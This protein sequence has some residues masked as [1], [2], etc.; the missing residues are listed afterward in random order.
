MSNYRKALL[1]LFL[2]SSK[3]VGFSQQK[4]PGGITGTRAWLKTTYND[5]KKEY[6]WKNFS[7]DTIEVNNQINGNA[8]FDHEVININFNPSLQVSNK[9]PADIVLNTTNLSQATVMGVFGKRRDFDKEEFIYNI[10]GRETTDFVVTTDGIF[11][12][13]EGTQETLD[14]GSEIGKDLWYEEGEP[15]EKDLKTFKETTHRILTYQYHEQPNFSIWGEPTNAKIKLGDVLDQYPHAVNNQGSYEWNIPEFFIYDREL[16]PEER[17]KAETYLAL[18]YG[19]TLD[20]N[21]IDSKDQVLWDVEASE[22]YNNR[23]TGIVNDT[24][25]GLY[26]P[27]SHTSNEESFEGNYFSYENDSYFTAFRNFKDF[28]DPNLVNVLRPTGNRLLTIGVDNTSTLLEEDGTYAL[29][30]DDDGLLK[31]KSRKDIGGAR[32]LERTWKIN[33]NIDGSTSGQQTIGN[34]TLWKLN[35]LEFDTDDGVSDLR[36]VDPDIFPKT[37]ITTTPLLGY[38]G[39]VSVRIPLTHQRLAL[40]FGNSPNVEIANNNYYGVEIRYNSVFILKKDGNPQGTWF[41]NVSGDNDEIELIK[42]KDEILLVVRRFD[43]DTLKTYSIPIAEEDKELPFYTSLISEPAHPSQRFYTDLQTLR[44]FSGR[45]F[46]EQEGVFAEL[47]IKNGKANEFIP[48]RLAELD[49]ESYLIIDKTGQGDFSSPSNLAFIERSRQSPERGNII[50]EDFLFDEDGSGSDAFTFGYKKKGGFVAYLT[51]TKPTCNTSDVSMNDGA[52]AVNV[53]FGTP[54]FRYRLTNEDPTV[55][56]SQE[57]ISNSRTFNIENISSGDY[58]LEIIDNNDATVA[59]KVLLRAECEEEAEFPDDAPIFNFDTNPANNFEPLPETDNTISDDSN[60]AGQR[61]HIAAYPVPVRNGDPIRVQV[62]IKEQVTIQ[63]IAPS[64][65]VV[66]HQQIS[67]S[68]KSTSQVL[69]FDIYT[70]PGIYFLEAIKANGDR[71]NTVKIIVY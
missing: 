35:G 3:W 6:E 59:Q 53:Q 24:I 14:Y 50:F 62:D 26:Q 2:V 33:T 69:S 16:T 8:Q 55:F 1:M 37:A 41:T 21:Y 57:Q 32:L 49:F 66:L 70:T 51:E 23:I 45:G 71:L 30:G 40:R 4:H 29:W 28:N 65:G 54:P 68:S 22:V 36:P 10:T 43:N 44:D 19:I 56:D 64:G 42:T 46:T 13:H 34:T 17:L 61:E 20:K 5:S 47:S 67:P 31:T 58:V 7:C 52:V 63:I 60:Q 38:D 15:R 9:L 12:V 25:S 48:A 11:P 18:K 27:I 39:N